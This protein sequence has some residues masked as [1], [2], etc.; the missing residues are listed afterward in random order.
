MS[1]MFHISEKQERT[2]TITIRLD[3]A[4][5]LLLDSI[6]LEIYFPWEAVWPL[7]IC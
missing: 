4:S 6:K 2:D 1:S 3:T 7:L 5:R